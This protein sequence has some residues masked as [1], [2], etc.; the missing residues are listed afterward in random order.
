[1]IGIKNMELDQLVLKFK[2]KEVNAFEK[3]YDMYSESMFGVIYNIT[4]NK[5]ESEEVMQDVFVKAWNNAE[6]Y[7]TK[8]GS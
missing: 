4:R 2:Q 8:K 1:M 3:L 7:S 6:S 5:E